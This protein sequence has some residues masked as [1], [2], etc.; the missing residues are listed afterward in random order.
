MTTA[1]LTVLYPNVAGAKYDFDYYINSHMPLA[2]AKWKPLGCLSWTVAKYQPDPD[3]QPPRY[4]FAGLIRFSSLE[5]VRKA[6]ASTETAELMEDVPNY[7]NQE[8]QF[9][10]AEDTETTTA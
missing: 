7:S 8:L 5:A 9:L 6:L 1:T 3:G 2:A 10:M 4:A